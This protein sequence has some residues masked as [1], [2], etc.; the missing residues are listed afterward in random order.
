MLQL[1]VLTVD[2][3]LVVVDEGSV[4]SCQQVDHGSVDVVLE[5][6]GLEV[7][8]RDP[9]KYEGKR[10]RSVARREEKE[11]YGTGSAPCPAP[12]DLPLRLGAEALP[13]QPLPCQI[14]VLR[15]LIRVVQH[16]RFTCYST[17]VSANNYHRG[18]P[19][20]FVSPFV[21]ITH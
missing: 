14:H 8:F 17:H 4:D 1:Y 21:L 19:R 9:G 13:S 20:G 2:E 15:T 6:E 11:R 10:R 5:I 7:A 16:S 18:G 3:F 12:L